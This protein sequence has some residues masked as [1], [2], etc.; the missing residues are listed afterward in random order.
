MTCI[1]RRGE[2]EGRENNESTQNQQELVTDE[3]FRNTQVLPPVPS[4]EENFSKEHQPFLGVYSII[5]DIHSY[6]Q[7]DVPFYETVNFKSTPLVEGMR[8]EPDFEDKLD[9]YSLEVIDGKLISL[10]SVVSFD[11][12]KTENTL[13]PTSPPEAESALLPG[14]CM[15]TDM[16][17]R[18]SEEVIDG[19]KIPL[20][21]V[22]NLDKKTKNRRTADDALKPTSPPEAES[23]LL[24]GE[25]IP[26]CNATD[27]AMLE[28]GP[29]SLKFH[30]P[31]PSPPPL[32]PPMS[33]PPPL[34]PRM[35]PS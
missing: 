26:P 4:E 8:L 15:L 33:P 11:N 25:C 3:K 30:S 20:Y 22:V 35:S 32:P 1:F 31:S 12:L 9:R 16:P 14:E 21:S 10:Y 28:L 19:R 27:T 23:A 17:E 5:N 6:H 2:R 34:P 13:K 24:Q 7:D 29:S 18:S